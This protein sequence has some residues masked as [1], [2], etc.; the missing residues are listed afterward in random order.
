MPVSWIPG[1]GYQGNAFVIGNVLIDAGIL[2][3]VVQPFREQ[4]DIIVLTHCH[5]DHTA[6]LKEIAHICGAKVAIHTADAP[7]LLDETFSLSL[8]FGS[9]AAG[10]IPDRLIDEGDRV[11]PLQVLHTPGSICL[12]LE[13]EK[14]LISGDTVFSDGG[15]GRFDFPGG[16]RM[17]LGLSLERLAR[18]PV[19]GLY[20][21]HGSP[22]EK[23]GHRHIAAAVE[24]LKS[25]YG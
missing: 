22:V 17:A 4:I 15:F 5:H 1:R 2:P 19:E 3:S 23:N 24:L 6:H 8:H 25:G 13:D 16:D 14:A 9:R 11:G 12:Y 18:L 10:I 7:G 20:P 21:G